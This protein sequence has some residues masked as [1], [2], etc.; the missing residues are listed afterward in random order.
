MTA[1]VDITKVN[2]EGLRRLW[3]GALPR[4]LSTLQR[5]E[6]VVVCCFAPSDT[7][8]R[9]HRAHF[10]DDE[11]TDKAK[12]I[13]ETA[14]GFVVSA[15]E[16]DV[17]VAVLCSAG[18]NRSCLVAARAIMIHMEESAEHAIDLLRE[19]RDHALFNQGFV[20]YL[21]SK[22]A[23]YATWGDGSDGVILCSHADGVFAAPGESASPT[24][25]QTARG[26]CGTCNAPMVR[27]AANTRWEV[28]R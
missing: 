26:V 5:F 22:C 24:I 4:D 27:D 13:V 11:L 10:E 21:R 1:M 17:P 7:P 19:T 14:A 16:R 15:L 20:D 12:G 18:Q 3:V 6:E 28:K 25:Q 23:S 9:F 2:R 8:M